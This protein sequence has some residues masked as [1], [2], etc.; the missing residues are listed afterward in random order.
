MELKLKDYSLDGKCFF[1]K[2]NIFDGQTQDFGPYDLDD[3]KRLFIEN[4]IAGGAFIFCSS[5]SNWKVLAD[6]ADYVEIFE[7][8]PPEVTSTQRRIM[9]R[10]EL[11]SEATL[12]NDQNR[13]SIRTNDLSMLA[14]KIV[15][16]DINYEFELDEAFKLVINHPKFID[17]QFDVNVL[18][19]FDSNGDET[20][21]TLRFMQLSKDQ[22]NLISN[23]VHF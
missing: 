2:V 13:F 5:M 20:A 12:I 6:F 10:K 8:E 15:Y 9:T 11:E 19:L 18:R 23:F 1:I 4:R 3:L 22:K 16:T 14:V 21:I 17:E 7:E